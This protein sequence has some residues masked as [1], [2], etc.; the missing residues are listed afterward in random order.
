[1]GPIEHSFLKMADEIA[2]CFVLRGNSVVNYLLIQV[3]VLIVV[4]PTLTE[5]H[6]QHTI[7]VQFGPI[8]HLPQFSL[9][10]LVYLW[11]YLV[12]LVHLGLVGLFIVQF[13]LFIPFRSS[14][15][16]FSPLHLIWFILVHFSPFDP[17]QRC[18]ERRCL[19]KK[20]SFFIDNYFTF[21]SLN[22]M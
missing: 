18:F 15:V 14:S 1:M 13:G 20:R 12:Y 21:S 10:Y 11:F 4:T 5:P 22:V 19:C 16:N 3:E 2:L 8:F 9:L 6:Y 17:L 7:L